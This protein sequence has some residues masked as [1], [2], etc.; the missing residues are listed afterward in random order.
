MIHPTTQKLVNLDKSSY[1]PLERVAELFEIDT[2]TMRAHLEKHK[3]TLRTY[4]VVGLRDLVLLPISTVKGII[5]T[6]NNNT[7]SRVKADIDY[8][9]NYIQR[10]R[11]D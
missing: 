4:Q 3:D 8:V 5:E 6:L 2:F 10:R 11:H 7:A 9:H 1:L